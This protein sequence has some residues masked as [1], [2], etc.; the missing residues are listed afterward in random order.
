MYIISPSVLSADFS[1]LADEI[2]K[3]DEAGCEYIHLDVMDGSFVPNITFGPAVIKSI[4]KT[5]DKIFD[6]HLMVDDPIRFLQDYKM[7]G[8]DIVTVHLEAC[9]HLHRTVTAIK[10]L[11]M[12][13]GVA[14]N[15]STPVSS[16]ECILEDIDMAVIMS[17]NPGFGGQKFIPS[18]VRKVKELK[19]MV[20][21]GKLCVDIEVDG[22][23]TPDI[24]PILL[25]AGANILVA[26][27]AVFK[28]DSELNVKAFKDI[29]KRY[30]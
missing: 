12:K 24:A 4:R 27:S 20:E 17:V 29:F 8:A 2:S 18:S 23:I 14:I 11:G 10:E 13:A 21:T 19:Q 16:L 5:T 1:H 6:V 22:G 3:I 26:G 15:P 30:E 9:K 25:E 28:G 7:C